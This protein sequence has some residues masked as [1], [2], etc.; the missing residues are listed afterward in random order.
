MQETLTTADVE[1]PAQPK[2]PL[3]SV[4]LTTQIGAL[5]LSREFEGIVTALGSIQTSINEQGLTAQ[6]KNEVLQ[7]LYASL[8]AILKALTP[9]LKSQN[10]TLL[11]P[12]EVDGKTVRVTTIFLK[13]KQFASMS[14]SMSADNEYPQAIGSAVTYCCRYSIRALLGL[15]VDGPGDLDDDGNS[16]SGIS[17]GSAS[18]QASKEGT[19]TKPSASK[20]ASSKGEDGDGP[21]GYSES[22]R[23]YLKKVKCSDIAGLTSAKSQVNA[24]KLSKDEE[25]ILLSKINERMEAL[26]PPSSNTSD[27]TTS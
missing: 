13:G 18:A 19:A 3:Q 25:E 23:N 24:F 15:A 21:A 11:Q 9:H 17:T 6:T 27:E 10:V 22:L 16:A 7:N 2:T 14:A 20:P 26:A 12:Y 4:S 8:P 5:T 1:V